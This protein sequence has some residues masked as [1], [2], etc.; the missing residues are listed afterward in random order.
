[1]DAQEYMLQWDKFNKMIQ[2]KKEEVRKE[3][4]KA[5]GTTGQSDGDRVQSSGSKQKMADAVHRYTDLERE[6]DGLEQK[7]R[8][9]INT[10]EQLP[11]DLYDVL[12]K[13]YIQSLSLKAIAVSVGKSYSWASTHHRQALK[14]LGEILERSRNE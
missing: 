3:R 13:Y 5:Q 6:I 14:C 1:M 8:E 11:G 9:I 12:H 7:K 2:N 4:D 10:I